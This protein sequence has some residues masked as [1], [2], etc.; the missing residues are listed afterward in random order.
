[1]LMLMLVLMPMLMLMLMPMPIRLEQAKS[2]SNGAWHL[3]TE[4]ISQ[5]LSDVL[6]AL[7][8]IANGLIRHDEGHA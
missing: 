7:C 3:L 8:G 4:I 2:N 1:M 5:L 6:V